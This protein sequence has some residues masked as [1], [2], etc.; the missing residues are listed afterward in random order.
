MHP[1]ALRRRVVYALTAVIGVSG[2]AVIAPPVAVAATTGLI[3]TAETTWRYVDDGLDP[4]AGLPD[5]TDWTDPEFDDAAWKTATGSFGAKGGELVSVS[6]FLPN[7]LLSQYKSGGTTNIET[8]FFRTDVTVPAGGLDGV[9]AMDAAI[10]YDDAAIVYVNGDRVAGFDADSINANLQYGGSNADVPKLA[11]FTIPADAFVEG[12]NTVAVELHQGRASSSDI[13]FDFVSL[14]PSD[15]AP[16]PAHVSDLILNIGADETQ[17]NVNWYSTSTADE[18]VELA[19]AAQ[20]VDGALPTTGIAT[21]TSTK[22]AANESGKTY[23]K[24]T[25]TDLEPNTEYAYRVGQEGVWSAVHRFAT[26]DFDNSYDFLYVG[27]PQIGS[28]GDIARDTAGWSDTLEK[29]EI[30]VPTAEW[31]LTAGDQVNVASSETEYDGF[32]SPHRVRELAT[33]TTMGNHE[34]GNATVYHQHY[35]LP[36]YDAETRDYWFTYGDTLY[37]NIDSN[38]NTAAEREAHVAWMEEALA[39]NPDTEWQVV[40]MHHAMYSSGP[41]ATDSDVVARRAYFSG[42]F[43]RLGVDLAL[44]G[45]DHVYTR[46]HPMDGTTPVPATASE[47]GG[48][49]EIQAHAGRVLYMTASSASGSKFYGSSSA[50]AGWVA[51]SNDLRIPQFTKVSVSDPEIRLTTYRTDTMAVVDEVVLADD[52][53]EPGSGPEDERTPTLSVEDDETVSG[54]V[55]L[56][57]TRPGAS[58]DS[59]PEDL[60]IDVDGEP[61][62]VEV[63]GGS[64]EAVIE[65]SGWQSPFLNDVKLNGRSL[66]PPVGDVTGTMRLSIPDGLLE[67]GTNTLR[68]STASSVEVEDTTRNND[69]FTISDPRIEIG[70]GEVVLRDPS[71]DR[72]EK[73]FLGDGFP[74]GSAPNTTYFREFEFTV[75]PDLVTSSYVATWDTTTETEGAHTVTVTSPGGR[76]SATVT[77]DNIKDP[78]PGEEHA[79][80]LSLSNGDVVTGGL[81]VVATRVN[82]PA[83]TASSEDVEITVDG[84][85]LPVA[86]GQLGESTAAIDVRGWQSGFVQDVKLNGQSLNPPRANLDGTMR[87]PVP[88]GLLQEGENTLRVSTGSSVQVEDTTR[89]NDD[90]TISDPRLE[91]GGVDFVLRDPSVDPAAS[92]FIGDGFPAGSAPETTYFREFTF[93][94]EPGVMTTYVSVWDTTLVEDGE[95]VV[96]ATSPGGTTSAK[97]VSDNTAPEVTFT[98]PIEGGRY[99]GSFTVDVTADDATGLAT[100]GL[101]LDGEP[102]EPGDT[103]DADAIGDGEHTLVARAVDDLGNTDEVAVTFETVGNAPEEPADPRPADGATGIDPKG[104]AL[105]VRATDPAGDALDVEFLWG[106]ETTPTTASSGSSRSALPSLG[107]GERAEAAAVAVPDGESLVTPGDGSYPFQKFEVGVPRD[108]GAKRFLVSWSGSVPDGHRAAL[109][110]WNHTSERWQLLGEGEGA[111]LTLEAEATV[112]DFVRDGVATVLVQDVPEAVLDDDDV[113]TIAWITDTQNYTEREPQTYYDQTQWVLDNRVSEDIAYGV[114]TG[115][116]VQGPSRAGEW[117]V[118]SQAHRTWD[119]ADFPYGIVPG[120]HDGDGGDYPYY[121]EHFGEKRFADRPWYG[122]TNSDNV[123]HYDVFSTP[124]A[125]YLF[126]YVD[127]VLSE[128]E[129]DWVNS[130]LEAHPDHNVVIGTHMYLA[131]GGGYYNHGG[132]NPIGQQIFDEI[133]LP[134]ANVKQI[135]SGHDPYVS[136]NLKRVDDRV[137]VE[138]MHDAQFNG[139]GDGWMRTFDMDV[140]NQTT[141]HRT[142]SVSKEGNSFFPAPGGDTEVPVE[143]PADFEGHNL[144]WENFTVPMDITPAAREISTDALLVTTRGTEPIAA[145]VAVESGE[146]ASVLTGPL[147]P[148]TTNRWFARA[149]DADG[150]S[151]D[152]PVWEFTTGVDGQPEVVAQPTSVSLGYSGDL[153]GGP[154][155]LSAVVSPATAAGTVTF[156]VGEASVGQ[157]PVRS[158]VAE[159]RLESLAAGDHR[160]RADFTPADPAA[161]EASASSAITMTVAP[162]VPDGPAK[163]RPT[164]TVSTQSAPYGRSAAVTVAVSAGGRPVDGEVRMTVRGESRSAAL[165]ADGRARFRL[166]RRF[167]PG[168]WP[169][170]VQFLGT[171]SLTPATAVADVAVA[172]AKSRIRLTKA[173]R[174][175]SAHGRPRLIVTGAS[176]H[177]IAPTGMVRIKVGGKVRATVR[178]TAERGKVSVRLPKLAAGRHR[179]TAVYAGSATHLSD[180]SPVRRISVR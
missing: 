29:A 155:T 95:H 128:D 167:T 10:R 117:A 65:V 15:D 75:A 129:I 94:V 49:T 150:H 32:L 34:T 79:P 177:G 51:V 25:I 63:R 166:P 20:L 24:A 85:P 120:N 76:A 19:P 42:E 9:A 156:H 53:G 126:M 39:A 91:L 60:T 172:K 148:E 69:D 107:A 101:S 67:P 141:T 89:N 3:S 81:E 66:N 113:A 131:G 145:A 159:L 87:L 57:A 160:V 122:G 44:A 130:V 82:N 125:D 173:T 28:S 96:T 169:V 93:T 109:S 175:S 58:P 71:V 21:F 105:S 171:A 176:P 16:P 80:R 100:L 37:L 102:V 161:F 55:E 50:G 38:K 108:L 17:R 70:G 110:A 164:V 134:N 23:H 154:I 56:I 72:Q 104:T 132:V 158:G 179:V 62:P 73:L 14:D 174:K 124:G 11:E 140:E 163:S 46:S 6:G 8:F 142:F 146:R 41:H 18:V 135:L 162:A 97:V 168:T 36:N 144:K 33:S 47:A 54:T 4:A 153:T 115:D 77:V 86:V 157:A 30:E 1:S 99:K 139:N 5:R 22:G 83:G 116:I 138:V 178:L 121:R 7:T 118:A 149:T 136:M 88:A 137:I 68:V 74:A 26:G 98:E 112:S 180:R 59:D 165:G 45:H 31:L 133:V 111:G 114:H 43:K 92:L 119:D 2:L 12:E 35:N 13:Y 106:A 151:T 127:W 103:I 147:Q 64:A 84:E 78:E 123:Q 170:Q 90:F 48:V 40:V 52:A 61:L 152:S 27:D 143:A